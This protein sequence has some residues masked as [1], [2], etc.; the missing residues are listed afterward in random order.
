MNSYNSRFFFLI[1]LFVFSKCGS[2]SDETNIEDTDVTSDSN[3][4]DTNPEDVE[5]TN[6]EDVED[7]N[8]EDVEDTNSEDVEDS[9]VE[10]DPEPL[11]DYCWTDLRVG[12]SV[13]FASGFENKTEGI[14]FG[15]DG[16]LY[17]S[18]GDELL[19]IDETGIATHFADVPTALG[20]ALTSENDF[21]VASIG[22]SMNASEIDGAVYLVDAEGSSSLIVDGIASP[23]FV[24]IMADGSALISDD[25]DTRVWRV[26]RD[27][28][29]SIAIED[30]DS[31]NGM[32]LS[33][34]RARL[35]VA[36]TFD[37]PGSI[38]AFELGENNLPEGVGTV[39]GEI[40]RGTTPDGIA[41]GEDG[42]IYVAANMKNWVV[43][44]DPATGEVTRIADRM[45]SPA[46]LAFGV[47]EGFDPCS[48]YV[49]QLFGTDVLRLAVGQAGVELP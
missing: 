29:M 4:E 46:S 47:G 36:S 18:S 24:T 48:L 10:E 34:D 31:P 2:N 26:T 43:A 1:A 7:T 30:I 15:P 44:L 28:E 11:P 13:V 33:P 5:D 8:S 25:F 16:A 22:E 41:V 6:P 17:V 45:G 21:I 20:F 35:F 23:N 9:D 40:G 12:E 32:A 19:R 39:V 3:L 14:S 49:T 38:T 42:T 27:G 37:S